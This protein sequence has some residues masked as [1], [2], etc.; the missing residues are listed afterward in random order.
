MIQIFITGGT[1]DK[2][3]NYLNGELF[4][5]ETHIPEMLGRSRCQLEID[6][7]TLMMM[8]SL[9]ME[10]SNLKKII[11]ACAISKHQ[12]IVITH[13]TDK[14]VTTAKALAKANLKDKTIILTGA[15]IP[16]A[17]GSSSDGF[18]NLGCALAYVQTLKPDVYITMQGQY[19]LWDK[20]QKNSIKGC[21]EKA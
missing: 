10:K 15:M 11:N 17:F 6:V 13:G 1:F 7:E 19:F 20:V 9:E 2:S 21:F 4:F 18:F 5:D 8:D 16:Y 3:Y 14:M 12:Y